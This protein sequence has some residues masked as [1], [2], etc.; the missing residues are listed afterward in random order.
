MG[1][2]RLFFCEHV[3]VCV[4][5]FSFGLLLRAY[6]LTHRFHCFVYHSSIILFPLFFFT[7]V[8]FALLSQCANH[9]LLF[10]CL[11]SIFTQFGAFRIAELAIIFFFK[12]Y[13]LNFT[14]PVWLLLFRH[15]VEKSAIFISNLTVPNDFWLVDKNGIRKSR[16][17]WTRDLSHINENSVI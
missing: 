12:P 1:R 17:K 4:C 8:I 2:D 11:P 10:L 14:R 15:K 5:V 16:R 3:C 6:F 9:S 13:A 7:T